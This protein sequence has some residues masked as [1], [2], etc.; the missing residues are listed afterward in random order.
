M[1]ERTGVGGGAAAGDA[2]E[3]GRQGG[4]ARRFECRNCAAKS[5]VRGREL[6]DSGG[7]LAVR[8]ASG[9]FSPRCQVERFCVG[10]IDEH[11]EV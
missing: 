3:V 7:R 2:E 5:P 6:Q 8:F 9:P 1:Q 4:N 10:R 11:V